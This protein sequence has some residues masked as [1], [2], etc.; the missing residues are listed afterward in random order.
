MILKQYKKNRRKTICYNFKTQYMKNLEKV[1]HDFNTQYKKI[2]E[3][4]L[5]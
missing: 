3:N 5:Q 1:C 2:K 4:N